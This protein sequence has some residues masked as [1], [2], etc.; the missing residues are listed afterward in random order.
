M[1]R[2]KSG[3]RLHFYHTLPN[4]APSLGACSSDS[5]AG[6]LDQSNLV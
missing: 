6:G 5:R 1:N 4:R 2:G 3:F